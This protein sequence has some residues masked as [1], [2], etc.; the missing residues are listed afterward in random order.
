MRYFL[1]RTLKDKQFF[2]S[3][4]GFLLLF[5][6]F[7]I[8][9]LSQLRPAPTLGVVERS[10]PTMSVHTR[11][12]PPCS[13]GRCPGALCQAWPRRAPPLSTCASPRTRF[14]TMCPCLP[15]GRWRR[16]P[17]ARDT[18]SSKCNRCQHCKFSLYWSLDS[19]HVNRCVKVKKRL[20]V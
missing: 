18:S 13:W 11:P 4:A 7:L 14:P 20:I 12:Q 16:P 3:F 5:Y 8:M 17:L 19:L 9:L 15:G 6:L 1:L 10:H 2:L